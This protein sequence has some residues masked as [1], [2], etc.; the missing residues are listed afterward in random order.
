MKAFI[1]LFLLTSSLSALA[2]PALRQT[3]P[4]PFYEEQKG[5]V[6]QVMMIDEGIAALE[7]RVAMI[8]R[9]KK[10]ISVEYFLFNTDTAGKIMM[11]EL[12]A[13]AKRKVQVRILIDK[14][15]TLQMNPYYAKELAAHGLQIRYYNDSSV[16]KAY[17]AQFRNHRKLLAIDDEEALTGGRNI[18]DEYFDMDPKYNFVDR[19]ILVKGPMAKTMRESF[20]KFF[21]HKTSALP[22]FPI[23]KRQIDKKFDENTLKAKGF[24][25]TTSEELLA[26]KRMESDGRAY[27]K[28]RKMHICPVTS[29]GSDAPGGNLI[30][31][32]QDNYEEDYRHL[33]EVL[34]HKVSAVD[35]SIMISSPYMIHNHRTTEL[36]SSLLAKNVNI[37]IY[38][39]SLG[40]TDGVYVAAN[41]YL[42]VKDWKKLGINLYFHDGKWIK[43]KYN[44]TSPTEIKNARWGSHAKTQIYETQKYTEVM[45]G[46]Y[47]IDN[48]S[49]FFNTEMAIFCKGNNSFTAEVK[50]SFN[51]LA[52][53]GLK[54]NDDLTATDRDGKI[55]SH[56]GAEG[57]NVILMKAISLPSWLLKFLM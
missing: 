27:L 5:G 43:N 22:K 12:I 13:A 15:I 33:R 29:F 21:Y 42:G 9:A 19:D 24:L 31:R 36:M 3:V 17:S 44:A 16:L 34:R 2:E 41:M 55:T 57:N 37:S 39:N 46:T 6:N 1:A 14:I 54:V 47:N 7:L 49:N 26:R 50:K 38:S 11:K 10:S 25:A 8:R 35:K 40:A 23:K 48:R 30:T 45:I 51:D 18:G 20:D 52:K 4:Y 56:Y 28:S 53:K 32:V